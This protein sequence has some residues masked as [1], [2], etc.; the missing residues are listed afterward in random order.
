MQGWV[1]KLDGFLLLNDRNVLEN[2][3]KVSHKLALQ[4]AN[5]EYEKFHNHQLKTEAEQADKQDF[6]LLSKLIHEQG[7]DHNK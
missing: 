3:G 7:K 4:H 5:D 1:K 2:A 6:E